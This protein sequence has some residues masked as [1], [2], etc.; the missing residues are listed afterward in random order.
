VVVVMLCRGCCCGTAQKHPRTDHEAQQ[1]TLEQAVA[2]QP[3]VDLR[4]VDCLDECD[5]SNVALV[6]RPRAP[7][8]DRDTW[9]GGLLTPA[10]TST[11]ADWL[12]EGAPPELPRLLSSLRF[13]PARRKGR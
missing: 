5:R 2:A 6:R 10:A 12:R 13:K 7:K 9:L 3:L 11:L 1:L 4:V 8:A